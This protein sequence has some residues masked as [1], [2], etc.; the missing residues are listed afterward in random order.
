[1]IALDVTPGPR[2]D[3][4][5]PL[6][7]IAAGAADAQLTAIA[8]ALAAFGA[9]VLIEPA[10][11]MNGDWNYAWQGAANGADG[12]APRRYVR[13][14]RHVVDLFRAQGAHNVLW[15]FSPNVGN[16]VAGAGR[17]PAHWNWYGHYDPGSEYVDYVGA[18]GFHAPALWGGPYADFA[19]LFDGEWA[20]RVLSDLATR[21]PGKPILIGEFAAEE[22]PNRD[23]GEW[24]RNAYRVLQANPR[25]AGAVWFH[26]NKEADWR[27]DS[28]PSA[29][30]AYREAVRDPRTA[31]VFTHMSGGTLLAKN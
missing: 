15:V 7:A 23:K 21:F 4:G 5:F 18:H 6:D 10:W 2:E 26:M 14:W 19:T 31:S 9:T 25:V 8:R 27:I 12:E 13:M 30:A 11:E 3:G 28:T 29:L 24:M 22:T 20:D 1:M 16:P 17:G